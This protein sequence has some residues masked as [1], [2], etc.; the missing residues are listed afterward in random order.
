MASKNHY[1]KKDC[2]FTMLG[3]AP[4][5]GLTEVEYSVK[6]DV[7]TK[8]ALS[9]DTPYA[10]VEKEKQFEGKLALN[11]TAYDRVLNNLPKGTDWFNLAPFDIK[12]DFLDSLTREAKTHLIKG[13]VITEKGEKIGEDGREDIEL[14][15]KCLNVIENL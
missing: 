12:I 10:I 4:F 7:E 11:A 5:Y 14:P 3:E 9:Q 13:V 15:F 2:F 1:H 6:R 8:G